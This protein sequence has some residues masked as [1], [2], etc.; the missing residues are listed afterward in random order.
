MTTATDNPK[1]DELLSREAPETA[2]QLSVGRVQF[3]ANGEASDKEARI[4]V[5]ARSGDAIEHWY[6]GK[7]VHDMGGMRMAGDR[8]PF[9]W[10][11]DA[12]E[13]GIGYA[14]KFDT[15][16]GDLV[17]TGT[18]VAFKDD[19]RASEII[20]K[21]RRGV[22]YEAS[23]YF[24]P[25]NGLRMEYVPE[26][27]SA[28]VNGRTIEGPCVI[29]RE[30]LLRGVAICSYGADPNTSTEFARRSDQKVQV[31]LFTA[32]DTMSKTEQPAKPAETTPTDTQLSAD[33]PTP[34]AAPPAS[35]PATP[36]AA[37]QLRSELGN[38]VTKFGA[39][40]GAKWFTEGKSFAEACELH[41]AAQNERLAAK[42]TEITALKTKL[43]AVNTG[44][45]DPVEFSSGEKKDQT[46]QSQQETKFAHLGSGLSKFAAGIKLPGKK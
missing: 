31:T 29:V 37:S 27:M 11:H 25:R 26:K 12:Y 42:D 4:T 41:I 14:E 10:C 6:W 45:Q 30:W 19:D 33:T 39:E 35:P 24:D 17:I 46:G 1:L 36:D 2:F 3:A 20:H 13:G 7:L 28:N 44:E 8:V 18:L 21:G 15:T 40:N 34:P 22:P 38:F 43:A 9:D 16:S 5:L 32:E 23:I